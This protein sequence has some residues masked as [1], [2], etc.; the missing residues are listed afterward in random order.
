[1]SFLKPKAPKSSQ[2]SENTNNSL[3]T[4][5]YTPQ[6]QSGVAA[7]NVLAGALGVPG[8]DTAGATAGFNQYQ[9]NSGFQ[10]VLQ[11]LVSGITGNQAAGG[12]LRSGSTSNR[13]LQEGTALN[14]QSYNNWL[15]QLQ[16]LSGLG[17]QGGG[18]IA[19][20]GQRSTGTSTGGGPSTAGTIA[21]AIGGIASIF[22]DRRLKTDIRRVGKTK[23]GLPLYSFRYKA[24]GP[25]QIGVMAQDVA[26]KKP[27]ALG[28]EVGGF[29]TVN[30]DKVA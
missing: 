28:P 29:K 19:N 30:L 14:Q 17:L 26:K 13:I 23:G 4:G 5:I 6:A 16:G 11:R 18:I 8:G 25:K 1:M 3:L 15:Q 21:S 12:L 20:T 10:N 24:G 2:L 9:Q 7:N 22:S 27:D